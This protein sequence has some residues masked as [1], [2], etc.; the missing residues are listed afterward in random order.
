M[1]IG[2]G[3]FSVGDLIATDAGVY[4]WRALLVQVSGTDWPSEARCWSAKRWGQRIQYEGENKM[5]NAC[6]PP[7]TRHCWSK[8]IHFMV[9]INQTSK[10]TMSLWL[11]WW[12]QNWASENLK[13]LWKWVE[14]LRKNQVGTWVPV[15]GR[16]VTMSRAQSANQEDHLADNVV[17]CV[18]EQAN[19]TYCT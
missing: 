11:K 10:C 12:G 8:G 2:L 7:V 6:W 3:W 18:C 14:R 1:I 4:S 16:L 15:A 13:I 19:G 5:L 9:G 17:K